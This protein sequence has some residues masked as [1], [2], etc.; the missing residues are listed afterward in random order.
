VDHGRDEEEN[1]EIIGVY[2]RDKA[3]HCVQDEEH[4]AYPQNHRGTRQPLEKRIRLDATGFSHMNLL[5][6]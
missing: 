5:I 4:V 1:N 6:K 3:C 2:K